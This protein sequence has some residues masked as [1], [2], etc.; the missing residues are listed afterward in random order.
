[1]PKLTGGEAIVQS[2]I[3][4]GV[5]TVFGLPGVQN[6]YLYNALYDAR[7]RIR[8]IHTRHEQ[9]AGY[10]ALGQA[11]STGG[12][13]VCSVVPGPGLLNASAA[14]ATAYS[15]NARLLCLVGQIPS[16]H[17]GRAYGY[18]HEI[19]DQ[20][21]ILR[22]LTKWA[23]RI[24][25]PA[26]APELVA[27]AFYQLNSGRPRPVGLECAPDVLSRR[28]EVD[29]TPIARE[30]RWPPV[31]ADAVEEA[32][33]LLAE[34]RNPL[35][36]VGSGAFAAA[37]AVRQLAELLQAPVVS[38]RSGHGVLSSDH[39]LSLRPPAAHVL[40]ADADV[41]LSIGSRMHRPLLNW[42][43]DD[44]LALIQ[45]DIDPAEIGRMARPAVGIAARAEDVVPALV[46]A[47]AGRNLARPSRAQEL[48]D[49]REE[50]AGKIAYLE[51]QLSFLRT[52]RAALPRDGFLVDD[53]TQVG[54]VS[55]YMTPVYA[56]RTFISPDY[57]GT[58]GWSF[59]VA[60]GVKIANPDKPVLAVV[61]D[62]GF[63]FNVQ[64]VATAV[65]HG[66]ATVTVIF[67]DSAYGNVKRM[68]KE[69]YG[70]RVIATDLHNPDFVK[71]AESFGA[72]GL[73][74]HGSDELG[75]AIQEGFTK[76]D[77]PTLIE[78]PVGEMPA[79]WRSVML[80]RARPKG[81]T[82]RT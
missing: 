6:D 4:H 9:G 52:I 43:V 70:G 74:V 31:D 3:A 51:P 57:Q 59:A 30:I 32:A 26:Q 5:D 20:L 35:I 13:G 10:M 54:Y 11:L 49:L 8:V 2:L 72:R 79:P 80:G 66:I 64:E 56:P 63:M 22:T 77:G 53:F 41:V 46:A 47:L 33:T 82:T 68:Q 58:L 37:D 24:A 16:Y 62:G 14:L 15:S 19:P 28:T 81:K 12:V 69:N 42:G 38:T 40:W 60:L 7:D 71:L 78:V 17:I 55:R 18:L 73:R 67:N 34:S 25:S 65:Q 27:E 76:T 48:A 44:D 61:G 36:F 39:P 23:D 1:M 29:L 21:G 45:I 75:D 50:I